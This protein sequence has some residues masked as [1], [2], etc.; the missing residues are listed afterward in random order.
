MVQAI[1]D[2]DPVGIGIGAL[3]MIPGVNRGA[4]GENVRNFFSRKTPNE[5]ALESRLA[6]NIDPEAPELK[7][8]LLRAQN[9]GF[10]ISTPYY[11]GTSD[12]H[13]ETIVNLDQPQGIEKFLGRGEEIV[14][15]SLVNP[16]KP[17]KLKSQG[18][19]FSAS[20]DISSTYATGKSGSVNYPVFL[21]KTEYL[22]FKPALVDGEPPRFSH[23]PLK[24]M[25]V[26]FPDGRSA[27]VEKAF[28]NLLRLIAPSRKDSG[29]KIETVV[30]DAHFLAEVAKDAGY[31]GMILENTV[32]IGAGR[33][34]APNP[35]KLEEA[36][37]VVVVIDPSTV[38]SVNAEFD[39]AAKDSAEILK[40][41]GGMVNSM[42]RFPQ[43]GPL[44]RQP[45]SRE[46]MAPPSMDFFLPSI[47]TQITVPTFAQT[48]GGIG[49]FAGLPDFTGRVY[50]QDEEEDVV[51]TTTATVQ[52]TTM[53]AGL[54]PLQQKLV[55]SGDLQLEDLGYP[56]NTVKGTDPTVTS[57]F[58]TTT[59]AEDLI[60]TTTD[61]P[62]DE[63][64]PG[65]TDVVQR[66]ADPVITTTTEPV[67]ETTTEPV[68][69]TTTTEPVIE[70]TTEPLTPF[71]TTTETT[72]E[73][74]TET[75]TEPV[76]ETTT[77][78]VVDTAPLVVTE[79]L[80][81]EELATTT[82][83]EPISL[84]PSPTEE[85]VPMFTVQEQPDA[86]DEQPFVPITGVS[87]DLS[88]NQYLDTTYQTGY[89]TTQGMEIKESLIPGQEYSAERLASGE[90]ID[91]IKP[92]LGSGAELPSVD[93]SNIGFGTPEEEVETELYEK[94]EVGMTSA[95]MVDVDAYNS[96]MERPTMSAGEPVNWKTAGEG[97]ADFV[98]NP[99]RALSDIPIKVADRIWSNRPAFILATYARDEDGNLLRN[100]NG[101]YYRRDGLG[102]LINRILDKIDDGRSNRF[103]REYN[104]ETGQLEGE[105]WLQRLLG[106]Q[107]GTDVSDKTEDGQRNFRT[108]L[109]DGLTAGL[110]MMNPLNL[111]RTPET[112]QEFEQTPAYTL[113]DGT[114]IY[115]YSDVLIDAD[116]Y[117]Q[118]LD[119]LDNTDNVMDRA[120]AEI[121]GLVDDSAWQKMSIEERQKYVTDALPGYMEN[122][123]KNS[124]EFQLLKSTGVLDELIE[125]EIPVE[126]WAEYTKDWA[127][128]EA[129]RAETIVGNLDRADEIK[130]DVA[131][132][133]GRDE[134]GT[135][136]GSID[137]PG[138]GFSTFSGATGGRYLGPG[139]DF[140]PDRISGSGRLPAAGGSWGGL[141]P[142]FETPQPGD[143]MYA[144]FLMDTMGPSKNI[145]NEIQAMVDRDLPFVQVTD[146]QGN[147]Y[148]IN[149]ETGDIMYGPFPVD[150]T[151]TGGGGTGPGGGM[152]E[153][154]PVVRNVGEAEGIAG[155]FEN[156]MGPGRVDETERV[157]EYPGGT[158]TERVSRGSFNLRTG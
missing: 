32:D 119:V 17:H 76:I 97:L 157:Y 137:A 132:A 92:D 122:K 25:V 111:F 59:P 34:L 130:Q 114:P 7:E 143:P 20:P 154:G 3:G 112:N 109:M 28:P 89:P 128:T 67:I 50:A 121:V 79:P 140:F 23:V 113:A 156:M 145:Q 102:T 55:A 61:K 100:E 56:K 52:E 41:E 126:E 73:P 16:L 42:N 136:I 91:V 83:G 64:A 14:S 117:Q 146:G 62:T 33:S 90:M 142:F 48:G 147:G 148:L 75:T 101:E 51:P 135:R 84:V 30:T 49:S 65:T 110:Q 43:T 93:F 4:I 103:F 53:P 144:D 138:S 35:K 54:N 81:S 116:K 58:Q 127:A 5:R 118:H 105:N 66:P 134:L 107:E 68:I 37:D 141:N 29:E 22:R 133:R 24:D 63:S 27:K 72:T 44:A 115:T 106:T 153:G 149:K 1:K 94:P 125:N 82:E 99:L 38:R 6:L 21:N 74:V 80:A 12:D 139:G 158:M 95:E 60:E 129:K 31:K 45:F 77:E 152:A 96:Y 2:V 71:E 11:H 47:G 57:V 26:E 131:R 15:P 19:F 18:T 13:M 88:V 86:P 151:N 104:E 87:P 10:D 123:L 46:T 69:A 85:D 8:R 9:M 155:L 39:P 98:N 78:P 124:P 70:T 108:R 36:H 40:A 150:S 120:V